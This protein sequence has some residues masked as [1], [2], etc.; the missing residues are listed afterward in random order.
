MAEKSLEDLIK[1]K[2]EPAL[3]EDNSN[4]FEDSND[5]KI[6]QENQMLK[7]K[8]LLLEERCAS[9]EEIVKFESCLIVREII[10]TTF[11]MFH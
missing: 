11:F 4:S 5:S 8:I 2:I 6:K 9:L 10:D 3:G 7:H 1:S